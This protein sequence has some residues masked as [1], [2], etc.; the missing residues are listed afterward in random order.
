MDIFQCKLCRWGIVKSSGDRYSVL[1]FGQL[2]IRLKDVVIG[3]EIK[4]SAVIRG[5]EDKVSF[6]R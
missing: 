2:A 5:E 1:K 6:A 3:T 4:L